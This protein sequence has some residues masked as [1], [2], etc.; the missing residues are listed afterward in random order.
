MDQKLLFHKLLRSIFGPKQ[1]K[2]GSQDPSFTVFDGSGRLSTIPE[3]PESGSGGRIWPEFKSVAVAAVI[4]KSAFERFTATTSIDY[5]SKEKGSKSKDGEDEASVLQIERGKQESS[6]IFTQVE[7]KNFEQ[8]NKVADQQRMLKKQED[9]FNKLRE[10]HERLEV[11][12]QECKAKLEVAKRK[13]EEM[14]EEELQKSIESKDRKVDELEET[15][16]DL[17]RDLEMKGD[18]VSLLIENLSTI[19]EDYGHFEGRAYE[20]LNEFQVTK[21]R[22]NETNTEKQQLKDEL[23]VLIEQLRDKKEKELVLRERVREL[24]ETIKDLKRYLEMKGDEVSLSNQG[25]KKKKKGRAMKMMMI[26]SSL[27]CE[28]P[29]SADE[30][31]Y[32]SQIRPIFPIFGR[33]LLFFDVEKCKGEVNSS[34]HPTLSP[35]RIPGD[36]DP[37]SCSFSEVDKL[38]GVLTETYYVWKLISDASVVAESPERY[39]KSSSTGSS[40]RWKF[41]QFEEEEQQEGL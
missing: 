40:K 28:D 26:L 13:I 25:S 7:N 17:K 10:E 39:K 14:E 23:N 3:V 1:A 36:H 21:N 38:D 37:P 4:R 22:V 8:A 16:E 18:E 35:I 20:I 12:F 32:N 2:V 24:E 31:F 11:L 29:T 5:S 34:K 19:E 6:K 9:A 33:D 30:I 27:V 15:I 41:H